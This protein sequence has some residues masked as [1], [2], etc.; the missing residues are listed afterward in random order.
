MSFC[1]S[2]TLPSFWILFPS[3][4]P[5]NPPEPIAYNAWIVWYPQLSAYSSG[6][7]H[8][9]IRLRRKLPLPSTLTVAF[10]KMTPITASA[11]TTPAIIIKILISGWATKISPAVIQKIIIAVLRLSVN[12]YA[13]SASP[14][15]TT[16]RTIQ[17]F[18]VRTFFPICTI[19]YGRQT[20]T[21]ILAS[22]AGWNW[23]GPRFSHLWAPWEDCPS[24]VFTS[25]I[26]T[27]A[28]TYKAVLKRFSIR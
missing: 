14:P 20:I 10:R 16:A 9:M 18:K 13:A 27:S 7:S 3:P 1:A 17:P 12:T 24:G 15:P 28:A 23:T 4:L 2:G 5:K 6:W 21:A 26:N 8:T 25:A 19:I 22:S 11:I